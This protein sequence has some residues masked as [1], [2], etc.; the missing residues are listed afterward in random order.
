M[1]F[2]IMKP[3]GNE[4]QNSSL[5]ICESSIDQEFKLENLDQLIKTCEKR[6]K[7]GSKVFTFDLAFCLHQ[8]SKQPNLSN[9]ERASLYLRAKENYLKSAQLGHAPAAVNYGVLCFQDKEIGKAQQFFRL[10]AD[11]GNVNGMINYAY[12]IEY[13]DKEEALKYFQ[14]AADHCVKDEAKIYA[15]R[16]FPP[17]KKTAISYYTISFAH[18]SYLAGEKL[19][20]INKET[21]YTHEAIDYYQTSLALCPNQSIQNRLKYKIA[22]AFLSLYNQDND[23]NH[24]YQSYYYLHS[25]QSA[26]E[27]KEVV[28]LKKVVQSSLGKD[29]IFQLNAALA[30]LE[31]PITNKSKPPTPSPSNIVNTPNQVVQ[32]KPDPSEIATPVQ[33]VVQLK[34]DSEGNYIIS[35]ETV[36]S[37]IKA[38][39]NG[40]KE[41][42]YQYA[43]YLL[44]NFKQIDKEILNQI[45][46]FYKLA[47][48]NGKKEA[49]I[50][51]GILLM[52]HWIDD[53]YDQ[54]RINQMFQSN[55]SNPLARLLSM[56]LI[57]KSAPL[58]MKSQYSVFE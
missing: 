51:L 17:Q 5:G 58:R 49:G 37:I 47:Y 7:C 44:K 18:Q 54:E 46:K 43:N 14:L 20:D 21:R 55:D 56:E 12:T 30:S 39:E 33:Q 3:S 28:D 4:E 19:G 50:P 10:A 57:H 27:T 24:L 32:S 13:Q 52:N 11:L 6:A 48:L 16:I 31:A 23:L 34:T 42:A 8:K 41:A 53:S 36:E 15:D 9:E 35:D 45:G 1:I 25:I 40:N 29:A 26:T 22:A 2:H 38:S